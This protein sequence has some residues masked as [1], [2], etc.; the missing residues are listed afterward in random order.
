MTLHLFKVGKFML[1]IFFPFIKNICILTEYKIAK[2][3]KL[4]EKIE[5][6]TSILG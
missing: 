1:V 6:K 3:E 2:L 4:L 5:N